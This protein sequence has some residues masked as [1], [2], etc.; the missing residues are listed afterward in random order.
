MESKDKL[1]ELMAQYEV[2]NNTLITDLDME[3][4]RELRIYK[5]F[6]RE[7]IRSLLNDFKALLERKGA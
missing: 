4:L 7:G 1:Y 5:L 6:N 2:N 3:I